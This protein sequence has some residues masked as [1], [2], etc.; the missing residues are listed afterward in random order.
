[1]FELNKCGEKP[2]NN[3]R[4][5]DLMEGEYT[6]IKVRKQKMIECKDL[7]DIASLEDICSALVEQF[8]LRGVK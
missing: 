3:F 2:A 8:D 7:D 6:E 1:M 5:F 4:T